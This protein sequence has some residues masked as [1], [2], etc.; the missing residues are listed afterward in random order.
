MS[1]EPKCTEKI[2]SFQ[3]LTL[4]QADKYP[5]KEGLVS[6]RSPL[7]QVLVQFRVHHCLLA[8]QV[9]VQH[10]REDREHGVDGGVAHHEKSLRKT[11][12][13]S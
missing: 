3:L 6:E 7:G 4:V 10:Q 11:G 2:V 9:L 13:S 8:I 12:W 1:Y 5:D